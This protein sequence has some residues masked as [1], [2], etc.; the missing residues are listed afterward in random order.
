M[1][2]TSKIFADIPLSDFLK[3]E[4]YGFE[5]YCASSGMKLPRRH[6]S[7]QQE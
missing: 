1:D 7:S 3:W 2:K 6:D 4:K 5:V